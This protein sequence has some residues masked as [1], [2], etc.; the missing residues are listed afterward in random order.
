[1]VGSRHSDHTGDA[2]ADHDATLMLRFKGGDESA[3]TDLVRSYQGRVVSLAARYLGSYADAEDLA[4]E[5]FLRIYRAR[6]NYEPTARFSTW[7]YRITVNAGL[8]HIRGRRVRRKI[9]ATLPT[10][11]DDG[12]PAVFADLDGLSAIEQM[13]EDELAAV[14]REIVEDLPERQRIALLLNKYEGLS[15]EDTASAME[16]TVSAVKSLL[17]RA[18]LNVKERLVPYLEDGVA[19][20]E[21]AGRGG[22][23]P[24]ST[25]RSETDTH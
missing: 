3:F 4:Q 14:L 20:S 19:P 16:L 15:Y 25:D 8:N 1:V 22:P 12:E 24:K 10:G 18:R 17:T 11:G 13:E 21:P 2:P 23:K 5:V 9:A 7:V 6:D